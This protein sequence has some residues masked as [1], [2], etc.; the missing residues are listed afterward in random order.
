MFENLDVSEQSRF[1]RRQLITLIT[2]VVLLL[3]FSAITALSLMGV[4]LGLSGDGPG[5]TRGGRRRAR[6]RVR[7]ARE[8]RGRRGPLDVTLREDFNGSVAFKS[9]CA[10][11]LAKCEVAYS[12]VGLLAIMPW[13]TALSVVPVAARMSVTEKL[14]KAKS[15]MNEIV[16]CGADETACSATRAGANET[17]KCHACY[18]AGLQYNT[19]ATDGPGHSAG[20]LAIDDFSD[21]EIAEVRE[22]SRPPVSSLFETVLVGVAAVAVT[23]VNSMLKMIIKAISRSSARRVLSSCRRRWRR[24][25]RAQSATPPSEPG[26]HRLELVAGVPILY[27][28]VFNGTHRDF[29]PSWYQQIGGPLMITM[30]INTVGPIGG[31]LTAEL[32]APRSARRRQIPADA[33]RTRRSLHRPRVHRHALRE[34]LM[35]V[36]VTMMYG[37]G[38]R[39]CTPSRAFLLGHLLLDR[40][41]LLRCRRPRMQDLAGAVGHDGRPRPPSCTCRSACGCTRTFSRR[42]WATTSV[43]AGTGRG[44]LQTSRDEAAAA[45][46]LR[47]ARLDVITEIAADASEAAA[48]Q[49]SEAYAP[50]PRGF[51]DGR[52]RRAGSVLFRRALSKR[53][54]AAVLAK[55]WEAIKTFLPC[56]ESLPCFREDV[57]YEGVPTFERVPRR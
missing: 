31:N 53:S 1:W 35:C 22:Q 33:T 21:K 17:R 41:F 55:L 16:A 50:I 12:E 48:A 36:M 44:R 26:D 40:R 10:A 56:I 7:F 39:C 20:D 2:V 27:S 9:A 24:R 47:K 5:E 3:S 28:T 54:A 57:E 19:H 51:V 13:G 30:L 45:A 34:V 8:S 46:G 11:E 37:S 32:A 29:D 43:G 25:F 15:T 14:V 4:R 38:C 6:R 23:I 18:C 49:R 42:A 52:C